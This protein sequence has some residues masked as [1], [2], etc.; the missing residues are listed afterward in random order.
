MS[1]D[2][3][4]VRHQ[5]ENISP[6]NVLAYLRS[7]QWAVVASGPGRWTRVRYEPCDAYHGAEALVP[8]WPQYADYARRLEDVV[9]VIAQ[10]EHRTASD[11]MDDLSGV[12]HD[13]VR[14]RRVDVSSPPGELPVSVAAQFTASVRDLLSASAMAARQPRPFYTAGRPA[15]EVATFLRTARRAAARPG[16]YVIDVKTPVE[17]V[18]QLSWS[19]HEATPLTTES[20]GESFNR[21]AVRHLVQGLSSLEILLGQVAADQAPSVTEHVSA[22]LNANICDAVAAVLDSEAQSFDVSVAWAIR[23]PMRTP[24]ATSVQFSSTALEWILSISRSLKAAAPAEDVELYGLVT[25]LKRPPQKSRLWVGEASLLAVLDN[26]VVTIQAVDVQEEAYATLARAHR[27][28]RAITC[29]GS[30]D[31]RGPRITLR[32]VRDVQASDD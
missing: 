1:A 18:T 6:F 13:L 8:L 11:V 14:F 7:H 30:L 15:S 31:R 26:R 10:V 3:E 25:R 5:V 23:Q 22:G 21:R 16:S 28:K 32:H 19:L 12:D 17:P 4:V 9:R 29:R 24:K 27:Q 20:A 2:E